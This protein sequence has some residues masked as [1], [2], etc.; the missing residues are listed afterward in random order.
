[1]SIFCAAMQLASFRL[2]KTTFSV[3][4]RA[5]TIRNTAPRHL[6]SRR[7]R[8]IARH[9]SRIRTEQLGEALELSWDR[10]DKLRPILT[11]ER[12]LWHIPAELEKGHQDRLIPMAPEFAEFLLKTPEAQRSGFVFNPK[13]ERESKGRLTI[14]QVMRL[15]SRIEK[16]A[17]IV[18]R[19]DVKT[20]K[21]KNASAHDF[22]RAFG[23]RWA[24]RIMPAVLM[25][26]K[27]HESIST[28]MQ[29]YV[30]RSAQATADVVWQ[31]YSSVKTK[32]GNEKGDSLGDSGPKSAKNDESPK[33]G[34]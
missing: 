2:G 9:N 3:K 19:T 23:D 5:V 7:N 1:M 6:K 14:I 29:F 25:E 34:Q 21:K 10:D 32:N 28:T 16:R 13:A 20:G 31:A 11:G 4:T 27:R 18:V 17:A 22:R 30:G 8:L 12:P 33:G 24:L 15:I 26:M